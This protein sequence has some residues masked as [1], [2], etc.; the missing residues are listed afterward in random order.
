MESV[1]L[2]LFVSLALATVLSI[3]LKKIAVSHI[4]GYIITGVVISNF[5]EFNGNEE[6]D[7]LSLIAEYG[8]VF[9][10][11]TIGLEM[12][13]SKLKQMKTF[14]F[15]NGFLQ[16]ALSTLLIFVLAKYIFSFDSVTAIIIA[17]AFSLSSTAIVMSY[18]K[19]SNDIVTPYGE[20][21]AAILIFQDL[22]VIPVLLLLQF[23]ANDDLSIG[24]VLLKT[25]LSAAA[26]LVFMFTVGEKITGWMLK[27]SAHA[28]LEELFL[29][30]VLSI[31]IGASLLA[32]YM[33]FSYSLGA[34]IAGMIIAETPYHVKVESDISSYRDILL[35]TFF[36]SIGTHINVFYFANNLHWVFLV[37]LGVLILKGLVVYFLIKAKSTLSD[38]VKSGL[39]L[40]TIG[41]FSFAVFAIASQNS[42]I[43][44]NTSNFLILVTVLSMIISPFIVNNI[45]K[46]ASLVV[47]EFYEADKITP[48]DAQDH[49]VLCGYGDIGRIV[50]KQLEQKGK[51][52]V[53][54][55][56]NLTHVLSAREHGYMAYF[57]NIDKKPVLE[58]LKVDKASAVLIAINSI[59]TK[60]IICETI[61][62]Y[63]SAIP[64]IIRV[65]SIDEKNQ[66]DDLPIRTFVHAQEE[67]ATL[68]VKGSLNLDVQ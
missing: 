20:R 17:L 47:V 42:L 1:L 55:S 32:H 7:A 31:V 24:D 67:I 36:F 50:A 4:I 65:N 61:L 30:S 10:M 21:T 15:T 56:N 5:F 29:G 25:A 11:F 8:I 43:D 34:F 64:V 13:F 59:K 62:E 3:L 58:S 33:G 37:L 49:I 40:S 38:S 68:L 46:L 66:L 2:M 52:F 35:G 12:S 41:E 28:R 45:Y 54:I 63:N 18:L 39:A 16:V 22:A 23:L 26:V 48:I 60:R 14:I 6:N 53:I 44:E 27:F 51:S 19:K 9:L 57:G